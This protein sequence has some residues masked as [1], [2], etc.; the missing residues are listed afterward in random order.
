[1]RRTMRLPPGQQRIA[2]FPR[3]GTHFQHPAPAVPPHPTIEI[4]GAVT[5]SRAVPLT[6]LARL[7]RRELE[8]DFH[9][10]SGW[11]ATGLRWEGVG[12]GTFYREEIEPNGEISHI[13]FQGLDGYRSI[14][15]IE[16]ALA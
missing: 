12:F 5:E 9:C 4:A 7:P 13:V 10:V 11:S 1:M 6:E 16:D 14:V 2:G 8:T 15:E 3:F